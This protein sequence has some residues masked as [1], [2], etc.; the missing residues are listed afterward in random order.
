MIIVLDRSEKDYS[1][2]AENFLMSGTAL[3]N[4]STWFVR[5]LQ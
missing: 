1:I 5:F 3:G 4:C 2:T